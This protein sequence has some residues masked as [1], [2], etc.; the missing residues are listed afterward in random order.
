ME[1]FRSIMAAL[2]AGAKVLASALG[3]WVIGL[4]FRV[5]GLRGFRV[6][7]FGFRVRV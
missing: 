3:I 5:G 4:G 2:Q 7:G 6:W 1:P